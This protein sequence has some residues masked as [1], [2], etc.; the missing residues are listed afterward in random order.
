MLG[1]GCKASTAF[2]EEGIAKER[3]KPRG[4]LSSLAP[5]VWGDILGSNGC[6]TGGLGH[7]PPVK[8]SVS[9]GSWVWTWRILG[10]DKET[11]QEGDE[12]TLI[13][14]SF[15]SLSPALALDVLFEAVDGVLLNPQE[16]QVSHLARGAEILGEGVNDGVVCY[17]LGD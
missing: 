11:A 2:L 7:F 13:L 17:E 4:A 12:Q 8:L 3:D 10:S 9:V 5:V 15:F 16:G 6:S 1:T 14:G